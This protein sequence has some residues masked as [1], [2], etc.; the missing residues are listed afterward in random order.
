MAFDDT[1]DARTTPEPVDK[2]VGARIRLRRKLLGLSQSALGDALGL[3]FQQ[4]Q[5]YERGGNRVSAS[6]LYDAAKTLGVPVSYFFEGL[7]DPVEPGSPIAVEDPV[8]VLASLPHGLS[9]A[10]ALQEIGTRERGAVLELVQLMARNTRGDIS[11]LEHAD[12]ADRSAA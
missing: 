6:K 5:K 7:A 3:T 4:I 2:H 10:R 1:S 8:L 9:L 11:D 12:L